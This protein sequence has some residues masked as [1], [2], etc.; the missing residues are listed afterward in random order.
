MK[1]IFAMAHPMALPGSYR[2][3]GESI[4]EISDRLLSEVEIYLN[5]GFTG[6]ILQNVHDFPL[7]QELY[8]EKIAYMTYLG[9]L[10]RKQFPNAK[11]GVMLNWNAVSAL[12]VA[13]AISADFVRIEHT[14]VGAEVFCTGLF[15]GQCVPVMELKKRI[16]SKVKVFADVY[17]PYGMPI[18]KKNI[19]EACFDAVSFCFAEGLFLEGKTPEES[20]RMVS[21]ARKTVNCPIY[22]GGGSNADT[23]PLLYPHF[24]AMCVGKWLKKDGY[25]L[26]PIDLERL[27]RYMDAIYNEDAKEH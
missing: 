7:K 15:E 16:G 8:P 21:A 26:N 3:N 6:V 25:L 22:L 14:F 17:D 10:V 1:P 4:Q 2:N 11:L 20:V 27:K 18:G 19:E 13:D 12:A 24:D 23:I 5:G 9:S